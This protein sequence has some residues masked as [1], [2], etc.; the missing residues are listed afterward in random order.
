MGRITAIRFM[1]LY[2]PIV[3]AFAIA[4]TRPRAPRML[5]AALLGFLWTLPSLLVLQLLNLRFAWWDFH[6]EGALFRGMPLDQYLGADTW[7]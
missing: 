5:P 3:G 4:I 6:V 7:V 2:I 1:G